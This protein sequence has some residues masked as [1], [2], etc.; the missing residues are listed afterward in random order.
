[1]NIEQSRC[2]NCTNNASLYKIVNIT[3]SDCRCIHSIHHRT[4]QSS[5]KKF[6]TNNLSYINFL[7]ENCQCNRQ[8]E[9]KDFIIRTLRNNIPILEFKGKIPGIPKNNNNITWYFLACE[10]CA[11]NRPWVKNYMAKLSTCSYIDDDHDSLVD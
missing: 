1:M 4:H 2:N 10:Y 9:Y 5:Y 7:P 6:Q 11:N 3:L 8:E